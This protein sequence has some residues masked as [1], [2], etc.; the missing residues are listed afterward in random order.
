MK[1][2]PDIARIAALVGEPARAAMLT[3]LMTG[4]ALTASELAQEAGI[5]AQTASSHLAKLESGGLVVLRKQ[6]RHRYFALAGAD[7]ADVLERLMGLAQRAGH[8]RVRP[9]PKDPAMRQARVCYDHLAGDAGV[10]LYDSL[11][12]RKLISSKARDG[13]I[14][15][16]L[17]PKGEKFAQAFGVDLALLEAARPPVCKSCLD[18]SA[19]RTHLAGGLGRALLRRFYELKWAARAPDSR[20]VTFTRTGEKKFKAFLAATS[21]R[22]EHLT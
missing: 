10:A 8:A 22:P 20:V 21:F 6:G 11:V 2:K 15:L 4:G 7:V 17:T 9:G 5:T 14:L 12:R 13:D 16:S 19:R 1:T 3:A 18:W